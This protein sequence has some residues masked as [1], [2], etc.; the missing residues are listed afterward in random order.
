ML[1]VIHCGRTDTME[2]NVSFLSHPFLCVFS[3]LPRSAGFVRN[4]RGRGLP[5]FTLFL[6][7]P[8]PIPF[9]FHVYE[10]TVSNRGIIYESSTRICDPCGTF[11]TKAFD[12]TLSYCRKRDA[13]YDRVS[14][15]YFTSFF[16]RSIYVSE[17]IGNVRTERD[18]I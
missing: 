7:F 18:P 9:T 3:K 6:P 13:F 16:L 12:E 10:R 17:R 4:V 11:L 8:H 15:F 1:T 2:I 5:W 14:L